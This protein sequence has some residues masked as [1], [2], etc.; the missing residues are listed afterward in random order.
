[1]LVSV[2]LQSD[3]DRERQASQRYKRLG[4]RRREAKRRLAK[5]QPCFQEC[6]GDRYSEEVLAVSYAP[7]PGIV[8]EEHAL[9]NPGQE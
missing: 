2:Q 9:G 7:E 6:A 1:M 8:Q 4:E 5:R 3:S